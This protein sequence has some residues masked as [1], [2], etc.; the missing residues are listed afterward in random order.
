M[1]LQVEDEAG[2]GGSNYQSVMAQVEIGLGLS[3][4]ANKNNPDPLLIR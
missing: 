1:W 3:S 4:G 2:R